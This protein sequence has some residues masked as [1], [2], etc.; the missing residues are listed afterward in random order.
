MRLIKRANEEPINYEEIA[1]RF[2]SLYDLEEIKKDIADMQERVKNKITKENNQYIFTMYAVTSEE[3]DKIESAKILASV[4]FPG[5]FQ[6]EPFTGEVFDEI[7]DHIVEIFYLVSCKLNDALNLDGKFYFH[8][9]N[10]LVYRLFYEKPHFE[11]DEQVT[12][13]LQDSIE[14][15]EAKRRRME[16][17]PV[18]IEESLINKDK[19]AFMNA[20]N[21]LKELKEFFK[22]AKKAISRLLKRKANLS[23][24]ISYPVDLEYY[25]MLD[26]MEEEQE[27]MEN[28]EDSKNDAQ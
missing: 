18:I 26:E 13:E 3:H 25:D 10:N 5:K 6:L 4:F 2:F 20:T 8:T 1:S 14:S 7:W 23:E 11:E 28:K 27:L 16:E 22:E 19:E 12:N 15:Y 24:N 9:D 21:E 17:L